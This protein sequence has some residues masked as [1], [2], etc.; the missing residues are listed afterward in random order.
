MSHDPSEIQYADLLLKKHFLFSNLK[1]VILLN[2]FVETVIFIFIFQN[3][4]MNRKFKRKKNY[5]K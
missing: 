4:S 5:L 3:S 2:I 1:T